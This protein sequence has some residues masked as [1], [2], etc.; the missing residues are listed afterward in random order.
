MLQCVSCEDWFH[1]RCL[2]AR[3]ED[4]DSF[5]DFVCRKCVDTFRDVLRP[6]ICGKD[7]D[8]K[9]QVLA[10]QSKRNAKGGSGNLN[11]VLLGLP[12]E[13]ATKEDL[14]ALHASESSLKRRLDDAETEQSTNESKKPKMDETV[15]ENIDKA[16]L[17]KLPSLKPIDS[18]QLDFDQ[19][20]YDL[21]A[22][23]SLSQL[24]CRC[25]DCHERIVKAGCLFF[26]EDE[27]TVEPEPD[28]GGIC[29]SHG[30][31]TS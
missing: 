18:I 14:V 16:T 23:T 30:L 28:E 4:E 31:M 5:E 25:S 27:E 6:Y 7:A 10:G 13:D 2:G 19:F 26:I 20:Q 24:L 3:P 21:F 17:C 1:A 11:E 29:Y 9:V 12:V 22:E 8:G 15:E